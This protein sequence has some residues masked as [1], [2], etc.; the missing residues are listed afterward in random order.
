MAKLSASD[1]EID[2]EAPAS[3]ESSLPVAGLWS[4]APEPRKK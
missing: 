4:D 2:V 3:T 1:I